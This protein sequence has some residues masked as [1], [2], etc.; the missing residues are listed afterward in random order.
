MHHIDV[1]PQ[2]QPAHLEQLQEL[3]ERATLADGHEPLGEHK[4]LRMKHGD[5]LAAGLVAYEGERMVAYAHTLM[6][7]ADGGRRVSCEL[8][9]HPDARGAGVGA[10]LLDRVVEHSSQHGTT[11]LDVWS[12]NDS[13]SHSRLLADAGFVASRRLLHLHRHVRTAVKTERRDDLAIRSFAAADVEALLQLNNR[14]FAGHPEQGSWTREDFDV[15][16]KQPW[17]TPQ[18]VL[19]LERDGALAGFCWLK[20]EQR[21]VEGLVG[22]IYVIGTIPEM[23]GSG[24]GR[25]L[26]GRAMER[27]NERQVR[28]AAIYVDES[29]RAALGL[30]ESSGFHHHHVD[31]SYS[32]DLA[33]DRPRG[34]RIEAAA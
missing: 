33:A 7:G 12:Y 17:F 4:F 2:L 34:G 25:Y 19:L 20:V 11:R 28:V 18:D 21:G 1:I 9:V 16:M 8:V 29:N 15:R 32:L 30:Y 3:V 22:E 14:I 13:P 26:L 27:L 31:V 5:D 10:L 24:A 6:Y 23:R